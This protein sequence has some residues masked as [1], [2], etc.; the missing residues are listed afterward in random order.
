M[1][2]LLVR[3]LALVVSTATLA[4]GCA[5]TARPGQTSSATVNEA[6]AQRPAWLQEI[7]PDRLRAAVEKLE[8]VPVVHPDTRAL[9]G[10]VSRYDLLK[11]YTHYHHE[12][13]VRERMFRNQA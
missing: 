6:T 7:S 10:I 5:T 13:K 4:G 1:R 3:R 2:S 11:P 12:E 8:R 9:L